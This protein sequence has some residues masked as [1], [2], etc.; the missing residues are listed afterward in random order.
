MIE[1]DFAIVTAIRQMELEHLLATQS[2]VPPELLP[3]G[4]ADYKGG[5][6]SLM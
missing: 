6:E 1:Q 3:A 2:D 5:F 4:K